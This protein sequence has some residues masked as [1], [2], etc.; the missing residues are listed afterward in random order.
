MSTPE[1]LLAASL[2]L[3]MLGSAN[4]M[5]PERAVIKP[6]NSA[7][8]TSVVSPHAQL[9]R[10]LLQPIDDPGR[11]RGYRI[12]ILAADG[13]DGFDLEVPRRFLAERGATVH[14]IISRPAENVQGG[15]SGALRPAKTEITVF[16]P[17]GEQHSAS[18]DRFIDQV[19]VCEYDI[20]YLPS[21]RA[22][23]AGLSEPVGIAF[24][25]QAAREGKP[26]FA[27]GNSAFVLLKAG[28]LDDGPA[29]GDPVM[30]ASVTSSAT[31]TDVPLVNDVLIYT[32]R[33]AFDIPVLMDNLVAALLGRPLLRQ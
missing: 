23:P 10:F 14:V 30:A 19:Q 13:V 11:L 27:T 1:V 4:A 2:M 8:A 24:L 18:F 12:A 26:I 32:S 17:S 5:A 15:G 20:V 9:M 16:E 21:N 7:A 6:A 29:A 3:Y 31:A 33:D 22:F 28:L 25:Q